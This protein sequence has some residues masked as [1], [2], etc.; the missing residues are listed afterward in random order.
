MARITKILS[1]S[2][3]VNPAPLGRFVYG[4]VSDRLIESDDAKRLKLYRERCEE[5]IADIKRHVND[6]GCVAL[7]ADTENV[8]EYCG[9]VWTEKSQT[10][11]GGC[12]DRDIEIQEAVE[13]KHEELNET[14][15]F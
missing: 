15:P 14:S 6:V 7:S 12:C 3:E 4:G 1:Y 10:Y 5:I 11:N 8:C 13:T 9:D 2:V